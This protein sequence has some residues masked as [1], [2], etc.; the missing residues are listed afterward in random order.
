MDLKVQRTQCSI[1]KHY[2][3]LSDDSNWED[4]EEEE[5]VERDDE[6]SVE[7]K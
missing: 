5:D 4:I 6:I 2:N 3:S 1:L 7:E